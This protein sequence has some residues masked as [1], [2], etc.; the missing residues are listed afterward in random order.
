M[1]TTLRTDTDLQQEAAQMP[2][3]KKLTRVGERAWKD[4]G[5][6]QLYAIHSRS[7]IVGYLINSTIL[8]K[9]VFYPDKTEFPRMEEEDVKWSKLLVEGVCA[10]CGKK[11]S[12][13]WAKLVNTE[14]SCVTGE[15]T[16]WQ[17]GILETCITAVEKE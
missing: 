5:Y 3:P 11:H 10:V 1:S 8:C 15:L 16:E 17:E 13:P 6:I 7:P 14:C 4:A 2:W 12:G 9:K